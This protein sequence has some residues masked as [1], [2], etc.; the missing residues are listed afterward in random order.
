MFIY[1]ALASSV[2]ADLVFTFQH[3]PWGFD[4]DDVSVEAATAVPESGSLLLVAV[5]LIAFLALRRRYA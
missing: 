4:F 1:T 3:D 2:T 5:G